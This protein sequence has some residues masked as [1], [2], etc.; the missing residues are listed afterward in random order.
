MPGAR[1][2]DAVTRAL[3][4][5]TERAKTVS[6]A[7]GAVPTAALLDGAVDVEGEH[8]V[9]LVSGGNINVTELGEL[10][11]TGLM[12]LDRYVRVR[13]ALSN[14]PESLGAIGD[15][16]T[17]EGA[18]LDDIRREPLTPDVAANRHPITVGI[19][20]IGADHLTDVL[21]ALEEHSDIEVVEPDL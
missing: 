17:A 13:L 7:A 14:W 6:E 8:V 1:D 12:H 15:I 11:R 9:S 3:T 4:L 19:E 20:G 10:T 2:D 18:E 16:V 5:L 21:N